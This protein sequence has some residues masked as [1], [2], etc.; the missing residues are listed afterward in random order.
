LNLVH[1]FQ[2]VAAMSYDAPRRV[3]VEFAEQEKVGN[4]LVEIGDRLNEVKGMLN[5]ASNDFFQPGT[6]AIVDLPSDPPSTACILEHPETG[7]WMLEYPC[8]GIFIADL[9]TGQGTF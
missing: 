8:G 9:T 1:H 2:E 6:V 5:P 4:L 3:K 7:H